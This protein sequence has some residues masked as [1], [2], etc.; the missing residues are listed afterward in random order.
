MC[1]NQNN[2]SML[3]PSA[4]VCAV[5]SQESINMP[6][7]LIKINCV[8]NRICFI[9]D[10][11]A[12]YSILKATDEDRKNAPIGHFLA[13]NNTSIN[14]YGKKTLKIDFGIRR[15]YEHTY[16]VAETK[17][18]ILGI[19]FL[20]K[21]K[22]IIDFNTKNIID[23]VTNIKLPFPQ[24]LECCEDTALL[25][26]VSYKPNFPSCSSDYT[27]LLE[28]YSHTF[29]EDDNSD[30]QEIINNNT[31]HDSMGLNELEMKAL[32]EVQPYKIYVEGPPIN[33]KARRIHT[34]L[35]KDAQDEI[36]SLL[37]KG[38]LVPANSEWGFLFLSLRNKMGE[39]ELL[40]TFA[41]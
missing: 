8:R 31:Q 19:D 22:F 34:K 33:I 32:E 16:Y 7:S 41:Y 11:G 17:F 24:E 38:V 6:T 29:S 40:P 18:D 3:N 26:T 35:Y 21:H 5:S 10:T 15:S 12:I 4:K 9:W 39:Q 36:H 2:L 28:N 30:I 14:V 13:A 1:M 27:E 23:G 25:H 37:A 20:T